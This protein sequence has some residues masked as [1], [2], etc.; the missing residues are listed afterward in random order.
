[1]EYRNFIHRN[2]NCGNFVYRNIHFFLKKRGWATRPLCSHLNLAAKVQV[3]Q[4][5]KKRK[6]SPI[7]KKLKR[8]ARGRSLA[9]LHNNNS[10]HEIRMPTKNMTT[11]RYRMALRRA[12]TSLLPMLVLSNK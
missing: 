7:R 4:G 6:V 2:I 11:M 5:K 3:R 8:V 1:M 9:F 12:A 10:G